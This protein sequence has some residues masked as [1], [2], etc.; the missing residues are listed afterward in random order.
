[1]CEG[2]LQ[3]LWQG[4]EG[5]AKSEL[6]VGDKVFLQKKCTSKVRFLELVKVLC[7]L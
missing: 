5:K 7:L 1:M 4:C 6:V 3:G 2:K